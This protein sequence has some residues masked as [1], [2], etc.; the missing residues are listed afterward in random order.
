MY[1]VDMVAKLWV[2]LAGKINHGLAETALELLV[3]LAS[4]PDSRIFPF[5]VVGIQHRCQQCDH[6]RV[7]TC[8]ARLHTQQG[9]GDVVSLVIAVGSPYVGVVEQIMVL[10]DILQA[11]R[12]EQKVCREK[13]VCVG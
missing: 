10:V 9:R 4:V 12:L 6:I 1:L 3:L 2:E 5:D 8:V 7:F 11:V 13:S